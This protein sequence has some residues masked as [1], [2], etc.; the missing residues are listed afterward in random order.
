MIVK[1]EPREMLRVS[2][3]AKK[4]H[5][6]ID[7]LIENNLLKTLSEVYQITVYAITCDDKIVCFCGHDV[8]DAYNFAFELSKIFKGKVFDVTEEFIELGITL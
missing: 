6:I 7:Y 4:M 1:L 5:E 2:L 8:T 3:V